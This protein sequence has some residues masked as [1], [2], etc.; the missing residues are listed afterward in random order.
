[1]FPEG[2]RGEPGVFGELKSGV[3]RLARLHPEVPVIPVWLD[4]CERAMPKG[5]RLARPVP[6]SATVGRALFIRPGESTAE[7]LI[8]LRSAM[9]ALGTDLA[10]VA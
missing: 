8:R 3:A 6:C 7:F 1:M 10:D 4:G 9:V 5:T 2:T